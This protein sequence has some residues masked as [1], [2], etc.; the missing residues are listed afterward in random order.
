MAC[1]NLPQQNITFDLLG[2][3]G[4]HLHFFGNTQLAKSII[5]K[6]RSH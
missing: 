6:L 4:F 2:K 5:E 3:R 1:Y